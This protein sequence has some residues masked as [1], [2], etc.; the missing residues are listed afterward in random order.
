MVSV[1][2]VHGNCTEAHMDP[3]AHGH[4]Q[5]QGSTTTVQ[6]LIWTPKLTDT[7]SSRG[8]T[9][10][11]YLIVICEEHRG[12]M[13]SVLQVHDNCTEAHMDP[14]AHGHVQLQG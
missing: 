2:Q 14:K 5:L 12:A 4:V 3:K 9:D 10:L 1:L 11:T 8:D 6:K 7:F 13:V